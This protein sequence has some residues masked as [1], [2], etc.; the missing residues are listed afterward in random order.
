MS[1]NLDKNPFITKKPSIK[2]GLPVEKKTLL[3]IAFISA[4]LFSAVAGAMS[5]N[6][7]T[8]NPA[9]LFPLPWD[10]PV[11]TPTTIV[12][13]S[14]VQNQIY[15]STEVWLNFSIIV[16][17]ESVFENVTSVYYVVDGSER[18]YIAVHDIETLFYPSSRTLNFSCSL[19]LKE[20]AHNVTVS[21]E[22]DSYYVLYVVGQG[23]TLPSVAMHVAS[24]TIYFNVEVPFPTTIVIAPMAS[25][26]IIGSGLLLYFKKR[27]C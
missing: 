4:L 26:A 27:K 14:P 20:G 16:K 10:K 18:Q 22:A 13:H 24:E 3:T 9:P 7:A 8:A 11:T 19:T 21:L 1:R 12:V 23:F 25:V 17:P 5:V 2:Q 6:L 15:N